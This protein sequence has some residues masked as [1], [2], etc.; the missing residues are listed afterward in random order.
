MLDQAV[1]PPAFPTQGQS[2][3]A[4][5]LGSKSRCTE[6]DFLQLH[7][8][9]SAIPEHV[10]ARMRVGWKGRN[11][12]KHGHVRDE[13]IGKEAIGFAFIEEEK[14]VERY[15]GSRRRKMETGR[16]LADRRQC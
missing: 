2:A 3:S 9:L 13:N 15:D 10:F 5:K 14:T 4:V 12:K 6:S 16:Y 1:R 11:D 7:S 8:A